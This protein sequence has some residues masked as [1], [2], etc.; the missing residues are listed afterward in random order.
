MA[1]VVRWRHL[2]SQGH[3]LTETSFYINLPI[4]GVSAAIILFTFK[5]PKASRLPEVQNMKLLDK[6]IEMDL[7]GFCLIMAAVICYLLAAQWGG[8]T[9]AWNSADV[10]GLLVGFGLIILVFI[11]FETW[12]GERGI[13]VP[14]ILKKR[15]VWV[16][17]AF[18]FFLAGSFFV[19]LYYL[20]IYFQAILGASAGDS[21][22]RNIALIIPVMLF[23]IAT[24][25]LMSKLGYAAPFLL[26]GAVI[27]T[28]GMGVVYANFGVGTGSALWI[29]LQV[30]TGVGIGLAYQA[31]MMNA[32]ALASNE[33]MSSTTSIILFFQSLGGAFLI[34]AA[35]SIFENRLSAALARRAP[36]VS[37]AMVSAVGAAGLRDG[38]PDDLLPGILAS[39]MEGL[40]A[41][42]A[43][44]IA[45]AGVACCIGVF[46]PWTSL[47]KKAAQGGSGA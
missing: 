12:R 23:E 47:K 42:F 36:Q 4:G 13:L 22:I 24:G 7:V 3:V 37:S 41:T 29:G 35:Q 15:F 34:S 17:C 11:A 26:S 44:C 1:L 46:M 9:K 14:H 16:A 5:T 32:E 21:G 6:I 2:L 40:S 19:L 30:L 39:Y 25:I 31:P 10:I 8:V 43:M 18:N 38:F 20:P 28:I 33:D 27:T 45:L